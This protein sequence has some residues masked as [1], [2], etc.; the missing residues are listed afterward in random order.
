MRKDLFTGLMSLFIVDWFVTLVA[1]LYFSTTVETGLFYALMGLMGGVS[2]FMIFFLTEVEKEMPVPFKGNIWF[3]E[4]LFFAGMLPTII[5]GLFSDLFQRLMSPFFI[6]QIGIF[7][8]FAIGNT[9][10]LKFIYTVYTAATM[11]ELLFGVAFV[12]IG[13]ALWIGIAKGLGKKPTKLGMFLMGEALSIGLFAA[14]HTLNPVYA[15]IGAFIAAAIFRA[16]MNGAIFFLG[17]TFAQGWH[18]G[19]NLM[20]VGIIVAMRGLFSIVGV[21]F[22]AYFIAR[23]SIAIYGLTHKKVDFGGI[24]K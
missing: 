22:L 5:L 20:A 21:G 13:A 23:L 8:A 2:I 9:S 15:T 1:M 12:Y 16:V 18:F 19:N 6:F 14:F 7:R 4:V 24:F 10:L 3:G 11:E 17:F